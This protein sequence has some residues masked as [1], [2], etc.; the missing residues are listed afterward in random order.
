MPVVT[1]SPRIVIV[2]A[3]LAG[4]RT[5]EAI[6]AALPEARIVLVGRETHRPYNRPP[7]SKDAIAALAASPADIKDVFGKLL[8]RSKLT[9]QD[10]ELRLGCVATGMREGQLILADGSRINADWIVAASGLSPRRLPLTGAQDRRYV[11]RSFEDAQRLALAL[12]R[13]A[14]MVV[15]GG[16]FIGCEIAATARSLGLHVD[17]VE[18]EPQPML[19]AL[20]SRVAAAMAAWHRRHGVRIHAGRTVSDFAAD[21]VV[22]D[23]G[24]RLEADVIVEALGALPNV[25]WL[26]GSGADLSDG[27]LTDDR[28]IAKGVETLLAVGDVARF[29]NSLFDGVPRRTEHWC[30]P[31]QTA[32]RAAET[33]SAITT[34]REPSAGFA[35]MPSFWSDQYGL[36]LQSYGAPVLADSQSVI[37]GDLA[38]IGEGPVIVEYRRAGQPVAITGIGAPP[39]TLASHATRLTRAL[40]S[41]VTA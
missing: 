26:E 2:G 41:P 5:A 4:L 33:I 11:L 21:H 36:R 16:G 6:K 12:R 29:P 8:L 24:D 9:P 40:S 28:M 22:L 25:G 15:I 1:P 19:R 35:P 17:L 34:G 7:L 30:V 14:R 39:A 10:A 37:A 13:S 3:S 20:G 32:R 38:Q 27:V 31:G 23:D 18:T